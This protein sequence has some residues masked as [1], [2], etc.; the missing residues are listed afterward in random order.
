ME[1]QR[2]PITCDPLINGYEIDTNGTV[3]G[4]KGQP[5]HP[6][7]PC[8]GLLVNFTVAGK[9]VTR[10]VHRLVAKQFIPNPSNK[11]TVNHKDGNPRNNR[12]E[13]LEWATQKEQMIHA[14]DVLGKKPTNRMA[15]VGINLETKE[16][17]A[18]AS[19]ADAARFL[20][21][22]RAAVEAVVVG[23]R[24]T[25]K[26]H[27]WVKKYDT[28]EETDCALAHRLTILST[29]PTKK[30]F[31]R[32][33]GCY[34]K[35]GKLIKIYRNACSTREDGFCHKSVYSCCCGNKGR[36][37]HRGYSWRFIE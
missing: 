24:K 21:V 13:N 32:K 11:P 4:R 23:R 31:N 26:N 19:C 5:L 6:S 20:G 2:V 33:V 15:I 34:S 9:S 30:V 1:Y 14:R 37:T 25:V 17:I 35:D 29:V 8:H 12:V 22:G 10:Q 3:F 18:F 7:K 36:H 16:K 28:T 27:I